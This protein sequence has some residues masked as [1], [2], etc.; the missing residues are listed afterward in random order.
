LD[1]KEKCEA[2]LRAVKTAKDKLQKF[3]EEK[4]NQEVY[5]N[6][7][8]IEQ[9]LNDKPD[10]RQHLTLLRP[11]GPSLWET[12]CKTFDTNKNRH[13]QVL[14][15][16]QEDLYN[17]LIDKSNCSKLSQIDIVAEVRPDGRHFLWRHQWLTE[18]WCELAKSSHAAE[19]FDQHI[20]RVFMELGKPLRK[21]RTSCDCVTC[22]LYQSLRDGEP[23]A[24]AGEQNTEGK[25]LKEEGWGSE[26]LMLGAETVDHLADVIVNYQ[27][28]IARAIVASAQAGAGL[29]LQTGL[30]GEK[31]GEWFA[32]LIGRSCTWNKFTAFVNGLNNFI[33][34]ATNRAA[35]VEDR[36]LKLDKLFKE[37]GQEVAE[38][39][40]KIGD[41][42]KMVASAVAVYQ[43]YKEDDRG[44]KEYLKLLHAGADVTEVGSKRVL[45]MILKKK[46]GTEAAKEAGERVAKWVKVGGGVVSYAVSYIELG[47]AADTGSQRQMV[48]ASVIFF[49]DDVALVGAAC[50]AT[51]F[52]APLGVF[53][54]VVGGLISGGGE[55]GKWLTTPGYEQA[56]LLNGYAWKDDSWI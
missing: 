16:A 9:W 12:R 13:E 33:S 52:A 49:G 8:R 39:A 2:A 29:T 46:M 51:V 19:V 3:M 15:Q 42:A 31:F 47:E 35:D 4:D 20:Q 17:I 21:S 37:C 7:D 27:A 41:A 55:I 24:E 45:P 54:N 40:E 38:R 22:K 11:G 28:Q 10:R 1:L 26:E 30:F 43:F 23:E 18:A 32:Y 34:G 56:F 53:L 48:W 6:R 14:Y 5:L 50:D 25:P 36:A 44:L